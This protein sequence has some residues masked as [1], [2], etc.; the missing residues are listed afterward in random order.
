MKSWAEDEEL[1]ARNTEGKL[2][3]VG[4]PGYDHYARTTE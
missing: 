1:V 4:V 3:R 2:V